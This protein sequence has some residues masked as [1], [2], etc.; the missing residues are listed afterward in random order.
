MRAIDQVIKQS[1]AYRC[2]GCGKC[3]AVCPIALRDPACSPRLTVE[4][5][6]ASGDLNGDGLLWTCLTC[7]L[8]RERCQ[9]DVDYPLFIQSLRALAEKPGPRA[10]C[11]RGL[12]VERMGRMALQTRAGH[13]HLAWLAQE[14][15]IS[16]VSDVAFF[17]GCL[18]YFD[19]L[20]LD[21]GA[22][23]LDILSSCTK[24]LNRLGIQ[25]AL[26]AEERCCG[27]DQLWTGDE[28]GFLALAE[29]NAAAIRA[30]K[31]RTLVT[32][33]PECLH[34]LAAEYPRFV[35]P[36]GVE[37]VSIW[38]LLAP[39]VRAGRVRPSRLERAVTYQDPCRLGRFAGLYAEP[40]EILAA[41]PGLEL[42][43]MSRSGKSAICCGAHAWINCGAVSKQIQVE[44]LK[45]ARS[46]GADTLVT[47]C[48]KCEIHFR[49]AQHDNGGIQHEMP[50][51]DLSTL[52]AS[53]LP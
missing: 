6:V 23:S 45:D 36:L 16:P 37:V 51:Q 34:T 11:S 48:P 47:A 40:R 20:S 50:I 30:S 12:I 46:T 42:Q 19:V 24:I 17:V 43:E 10:L 35:G 32:H 3:T 13:N 28:A 4:R 18:P 29:H 26:L 53:A 8:C 1:K 25:P 31:A 38:Q 39:E 52:V 14:M 5:V 41:I 27:H 9:A 2:V 22:T 15:A 44:R 21:I 49:C 33:C 7:G